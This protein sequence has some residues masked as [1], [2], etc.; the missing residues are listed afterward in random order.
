MNKSYKN[1]VKVLLSLLDGLYS[2]SCLTFYVL[3][4]QAIKRLY[5]DYLTDFKDAGIVRSGAADH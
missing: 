2:E 3:A 4:R 5:L 1:Y